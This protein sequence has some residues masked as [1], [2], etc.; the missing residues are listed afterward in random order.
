M[1]ATLINKIPH[2]TLQRGIDEL[3]VIKSESVAW[4]TMDEI[5][6]DIKSAE[7]LNAK[8]LLSFKKSNN[9]IVVD[10]I[11]IYIALTATQT[12]FLLKGSYF[13]DIKLV[14]DGKI[15]PPAP[16][17]ITVIETV[18]NPNVPL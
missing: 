7:A 11:R 14:K 15:L 2:F 6:L 8:A 9:S 1:T 13:F 12:A 3:I 17:R 16:G 4:E 18:S 5:Q 10:G